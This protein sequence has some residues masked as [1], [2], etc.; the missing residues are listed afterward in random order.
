MRARGEQRIQNKLWEMKHKETEIEVRQPKEAQRRLMANRGRLLR[1]QPF[2]SPA[3]HNR[4][5]TEESE[6]KYGEQETNSVET[7]NVLMSR[8]TMKKKLY[9]FSDK[10]SS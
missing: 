6:L 4:E 9:F 5:V 8:I 10:Q 7:D 2:C 1:D 3:R